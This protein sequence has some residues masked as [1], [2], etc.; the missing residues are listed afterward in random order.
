[1][2]NH[3]RTVVM[4]V[5]FLSAA[6]FA[7]PAAAAPLG[8]ESMDVMLHQEQ[9]RSVMLVT[10]VLPA[11][12]ALP[13]EAELFVPAGSSIQ[14]IGE[15]LGGPPAEDPELQYTV[16]TVDGIDV[17]RVTLT[18]SRVAQVE[19]VAPASQTVDG[20]TYESLL[21]WTPGQDVP[22]VRL[23]VRVPSG[24]QVQEPVAG[25]AMQPGDAGYSYYVKSFETVK[26][27]DP[28]ELG[29]SYSLP[30][31]PATGTSG[32]ADS[33]P[34]VALVLVLG[35]LLIAAFVV[36]VVRRTPR[37]DQATDNGDDTHVIEPADMELE[38]VDTEDV[39]AEPDAGGGLSSAGRRNLIAATVVGV[40]VVGTFIIGAQ[41]T[42]PTLTENTI[43]QTFSQGEPCLTSTIPLA[44]PGG[45]DPQATAKTLFTALGPV[46]GLTA[47]TYD[48]A[49]S[50]IQVGFCES[51][52]TEDAI[53]QAL[54]VTGM[55]AGE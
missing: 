50:T 35:V 11:A 33:S 16:S 37:R 36:V 49:A 9:S 44:V 15:I 46:R 53:R 13:A 19:V 2:R 7:C 4:L 30:A 17:Y 24:A 29:F 47:A 51:Q 48:I 42:K 40:L 38:M 1:M 18:Q 45:A 55:V 10:G 23:I 22:L 5:T 32:A 3:S 34:V 41:T 12:T 54:A 20:K 26:A 27:G 43:T 39:D 14:W 28:L 31:A 6:L 21:T 25:A 52:T 8:W